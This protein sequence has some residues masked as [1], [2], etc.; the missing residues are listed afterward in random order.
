MERFRE[1]RRG[2]GVNVV[3]ERSGL[4]CHMIDAVECVNRELRESLALVSNFRKF[5]CVPNSV[6]DSELIEVIL[7]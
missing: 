7:R 3:E 5:L 6:L 2:D 1:D 4:L